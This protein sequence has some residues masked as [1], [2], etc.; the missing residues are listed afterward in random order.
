MVGILRA[1]YHARLLRKPD[2][3]KVPILTSTRVYINHILPWT[4]SPEP[5]NTPFIHRARLRGARTGNPR[6]HRCRYARKILLQVLN[7]CVP[8]EG[9][10]EAPYNIHGSPAN[11]LK[12]APPQLG[13]L[14]KRVREWSDLSGSQGQYSVCCDQIVDGRGAL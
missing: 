1:N 10:S 9:S 6:G 8:F 3:G 14:F 5:S 7:H 11:N 12:V 4:D 2:Q 13:C